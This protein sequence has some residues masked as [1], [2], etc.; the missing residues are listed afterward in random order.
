MRRWMRCSRKDFS[1]YELGLMS[2]KFGDTVEV[3]ESYLQNY[4]LTS[5]QDAIEEVT[6]EQEKEQI[7]EVVS[8]DT[9]SQIAEKNGIPLAD[10]IA[11]NETIENG[12]ICG[13][14]RRDILRRR[15]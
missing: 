9:L 3:V 2:L 4:E 14:H 12:I 8:G 13:T 11:M 5:L 1:D 7:Y 6:K 15:L 10:L